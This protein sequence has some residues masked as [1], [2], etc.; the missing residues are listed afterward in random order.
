MDGVVG[1]EGIVGTPA[2]EPSSGRTPMTRSRMHSVL[3]DDSVIDPRMSAPRRSRR[4]GDPELPIST[5]AK[6]IRDDC[7]RVS[8]GLTRTRTRRN[9]MSDLLALA[10]AAAWKSSMLFDGG[11]QSFHGQL[12]L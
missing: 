9:T 3:S 11:V 7:V 2:R 8:N 4:H 6:A 1:I 12:C 5:E 10:P